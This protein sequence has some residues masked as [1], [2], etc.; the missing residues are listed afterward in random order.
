[1]TWRDTLDLEILGGIARK[2]ENFSSQVFENSSEIDGGFGAD[3][4]L[5]ARDGPEVALYA[6]TRK[7]LQRKVVS[8]SSM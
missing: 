1:M 2:F 8:A 3:A 4:R 7:L 6:T 5:L